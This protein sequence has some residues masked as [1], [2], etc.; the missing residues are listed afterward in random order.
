MEKTI[1]DAKRNVNKRLFAKHLMN[2]RKEPK[3]ILDSAKER[4]KNKQLVTEDFYQK[5][6]QT[7]LN[8][9][10]F[11]LKTEKEYQQKCH[12]KFETNKACK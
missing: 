5:R 6:D 12:H 4:I 11:N 7:I 9:T 10:S 1:N 2:S 8:E 3:F